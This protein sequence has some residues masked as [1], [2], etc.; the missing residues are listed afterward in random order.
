M[1]SWYDAAAYCD[2]LSEQ[3]GIPKV[4]WCYVPN[5]DG[6][7]EEGMKMA[8]NYLKR[9][10][11]RLPTE[12]EWE[13]SCRAGAETRYETRYSFGRSE[14]LLGKYA[15]FERNSLKTSHPVGSLKP[16]DLGLFDMH[17][18]VWKWCQ[19]HYFRLHGGADEKAKNDADYNIKSNISRVLL[20]G[21]FSDLAWNLRIGNTTATAPTFRDVSYGFR[22]ARTLPPGSFTA[23]PPTPEGGEK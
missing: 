14:E 19:D 12:A 20:G 21:S 9:T 2:W 8:P 15:W 13:F 16:N 17:G 6:K 22:A 3:E 1:V 23:L 11:Y 18:N 10:G 4:Q 7:Y 5:K